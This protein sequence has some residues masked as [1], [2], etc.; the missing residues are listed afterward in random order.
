MQKQDR[1]APVCGAAPRVGCSGCRYGGCVRRG[2]RPDRVCLGT[3]RLPI[4]P[5]APVGFVVGAVVG[6]AGCPAGR[7]VARSCLFW[8]GPAGTQQKT[9][10]GLAG[11]CWKRVWLSVPCVALGSVFGA[12]FRVWRSVPCLA[13]GS[14]FGARSRVWRLSGAAG[15]SGGAFVPVPAS[16][17]PGGAIAPPRSSR[18]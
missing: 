16:G 6:P 9:A 12:R 2:R 3:V 17:C 4:W 5:A 1:N 14:V 18:R 7:P 13:L 15:A 11:P 8:G 10:G